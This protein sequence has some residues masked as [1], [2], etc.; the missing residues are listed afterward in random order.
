MAILN[1]VN[2]PLR[3]GLLLS[4]RAW[5]V[6]MVLEILI[7]LIVDNGL[8]RVCMHFKLITARRTVTSRCFGV[9]GSMRVCYIIDAVG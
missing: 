6:G 3:W 5:R 1:H 2:V 4:V 7:H 8:I 9:F